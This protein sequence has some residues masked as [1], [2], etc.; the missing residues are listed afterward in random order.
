MIKK[1]KGL[2]FKKFDL[3]VHT[4]ASHD[5]VDKTISPKQ[6]VQE[7]IEKD[8][9]CIAITDHHTGEYIDK[10]I[11][12]AS[13]TPLI[14]FPGVE[15]TC[16]GGE[17]GI[18]IIALLD[19]NKRKAHI[20]SLLS[21]L[22]ILP[23]SFGKRQTVTDLAPFQ[24]I[25]TIA[26]KEYKGIAV[27]AHCTSSK[28]VLHDIKGEIRTK[29]FENQ[30]LLA[31]ESS[32]HDFTDKKKI[33]KKT[34]AVDLLDGKGSN[35]NYRKL[36]VYISSDS[37]AEGV[38]GHTL[39]GVGS[40]FTYFKVDDDINL[41]SLRQCF[42]D[43]DVRIRQSFEYKK[44]IWP[45]IKKVS[46]TG[47]FF[48]EQYATFHDGLN[49]IL[50]AK[51]AGKSLL[52]ELIRFCLNQS[53]T[54]PGILEDHQSK[55]SNK[56]ETYGK[57]KLLFTDETGMELE[58]ERINN[59]ADNNPYTSENHESMANSFPVLFMSQNEIVR[60][61]EN[62]SEQ[63]NFIDKFFDFQHYI[64]RIK[65]I[66][67]DLEVLDEKFSSGLRAIADLEEIRKQ[68]KNNKIE[69]TKIDKLLSDPIYDRYKKIE[70]KEL[71]IQ[72]QKGF[73]EQL[74]KFI[75]KADTVFDEFN[76]PELEK[77]LIDDPIIKRNQD[78]LIEMKK[79]IK[80]SFREMSE[81]VDGSKQNFNQE[82]LRWSKTFADEK[83]K[84]E[85]YVRNA[86]TD[87]KGLEKRRLKFI[88]E[89]NSLNDRETKLL[90]VVNSLKQVRDER[91]SLI[92]QLH[93]IYQEYS[94]ERKN[95]CRNFEIQSNGRLR[96]TISESTNLDEFKK[97]LIAM[98]KGTYLRDSDIEDICKN[99]D[100]YNFILCLL[101]YQATK[102]TDHLLPIQKKVGI[103][104]EKLQ[105]LSDFLLNQVKFEDL[106]KLQY[107]AHP[108]DRPEIKFRVN[109]TDY[110][111][112]KNISVG[113]K[114]TAMLIMTLSDGKYPII[115]DQ[116]EDSL[117]VRSVWDDMCVKIRK[118]KE[119][120]Q[121]IFT[122]HNSCLAVAAD[123]DKFTI[124]E[125]D[126]QKGNIVISGALETKEVKEEVIR[127]LEG[128]EDTYL[129]KA[130]K[131][132]F[133]Q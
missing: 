15:V 128:G 99:I 42:I 21:K 49:S 55:L 119:N 116:P 20:E 8:L 31:V 68:I 90:S 12:E 103:E 5:F 60:I 62:E 88:K 40:K 41:E 51:G 2:S 43:R 44:N 81:K 52:V 7:A 59:P 107:K 35:Y 115:I 71:Q 75:L 26:S 77:K 86:G 34:R 1:H 121:F 95:K 129:K 98:K 102:K 82:R 89:Q 47:G 18:H 124:V 92:Q 132:G 78:I 127:Y 27:L 79:S 28:G 72:R 11:E 67:K 100:P 10:I 48:N 53:S 74:E 66:E 131:Y 32:I 120:R 76:L 64:N 101:R 61:A 108:K 58:I 94:E 69:I 39:A 112:I 113:Q 38:E 29:I 104:F 9:D 118:G 13:K 70:S 123:T 91:D 23:D 93:K 45:Y 56:L 97:Q 19:V 130:S 83:K 84:Y 57:V 4:P 24:V 105:L 133:S 80:F 109:D 50:G 110:Q 85:D 87:K 54:D 33:E 65:N 36:G 3:H 126:A 14:V 37:I 6:I 22:N 73:I 114:C 16:T 122:T 125:S 106:L 96:I 30:G 111:L 17:R 63:I 46:V 25:S 117:D